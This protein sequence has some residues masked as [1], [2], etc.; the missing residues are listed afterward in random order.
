MEIRNSSPFPATQTVFMDKSAAEQLVVTLKATYA[1]SDR[2]ELA[3]AEEQDPLR[4]ADEFHGDPGKSSIKHQSELGPPGPA[5]DALLVGCARAP[6]L[7]RIAP[8]TME[9]I[10]RPST[11]I[12]AAAL[13]TLPGNMSRTES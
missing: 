13:T 6:M 11:F 7:L 4:P 10:I 12:S 2:G 9:K 5:T 3:I 1:I 8:S